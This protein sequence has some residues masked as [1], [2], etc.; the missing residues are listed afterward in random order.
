MQTIKMKVGTSAENVQQMGKWSEEIGMI[1]VTIEDIASQT[2]L[3]ALNAAI[4]AARAGE[5]GKGFAVVADEVRKLA[6]RSANATKE[7][8]TLVKNIQKTVAE[9]IVA[10]DEGDREVEAGVLRAN[11]AGRAL[12]EIL[13]AV[14]AVSHQAGQAAAASAQMQISAD[15]LVK[16][17]DTAAAVVEQNI[18]STEEMAVNSAEVTQSIENVSNIS[19]QNA[20]SA[21]QVSGS[22][23]D[24]NNQVT[25]V[26]AEAAVMAETARHLQQ[27][28]RKFEL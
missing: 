2:N 4:E 26:A 1:V 7:I 16:A 24:M 15:E 18:A 9:A 6:E 21:E 28:I 8:V 5:Q 10:M 27:I 12:D 20:I 22:A 13:I 25:E 3:L 23:K 17:V 14:E 11:Q 19:K